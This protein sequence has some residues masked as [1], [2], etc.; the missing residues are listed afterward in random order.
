MG[1]TPQDA[2]PSAPRIIVYGHNMSEFPTPESLKDFIEEGVV[3]NSSRYRYTDNKNANTIVLS[4]EGL[5]LG[6]FEILAKE[7]PDERDLLEYPPVKC[8]YIV[9]ARAS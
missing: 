3:K 5:A 8:T 2:T 7:N 1:N 9:G 6:H 4:L